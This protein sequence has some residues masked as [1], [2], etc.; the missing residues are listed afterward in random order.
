[1]GRKYPAA[2]YYPA[3]SPKSQPPIM[4]GAIKSFAKRLPFVPAAYEAYLA[5]R[6]RRMSTQQIFT[7]IFQENSWKGSNSVS[8]PGSDLTETKTV[9]EELQALLKE[10][11]VATILDMPCGDFHWMRMLDLH[12]IKYTGADIVTEVVCR[13]KRYESDNIHFVRADLLVDDL[14]RVD[15]VLCR[16]CLVHFSLADIHLALEKIC[17][18]DSTYLLTTTFPRA[19]KNID[20][21]TGGWRVLNLQI[22]PY[23]LP[24]PLRTI[25]EGCTAENGRYLDKS[26]A[27]WRVEDIRESV[28][29]R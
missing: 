21:V 18:S 25:S 13:N 28:K 24:A 4:M 20:I 27:L 15:L 7:E 14:P 8:G 5:R 3:R 10:L 19:L 23:N 17:G 9:I 1:M 12:D 6:R 26:L 22:K 16:D 11:H 29:T 2:F